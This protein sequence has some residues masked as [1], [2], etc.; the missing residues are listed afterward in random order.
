MVF[1]SG[2]L[3][4]L[5]A[6]LEDLV[7]HSPHD[8]SGNTSVTPCRNRTGVPSDMSDLPLT[9]FLTRAPTRQSQ[10]ASFLGFPEMHQ[11][12]FSDGMTHRQATKT[13]F[14]VCWFK[15]PFKC[16]WN[17]ECGVTKDCSTCGN[18]CDSD[19]C[20]MWEG[21]CRS[22]DVGEGFKMGRWYYYSGPSRPFRDTGDQ[23]RFGAQ[24]QVIGPGKPKDPATQTEAEKSQD[25][26][27]NKKAWKLVYF[28][29]NM[30]YVKVKS[31]SVDPPPLPEPPSKEARIARAD[32]LYNMKA[33]GIAMGMQTPCDPKGRILSAS[34]GT[35][36][37]D[38]QVCVTALPRDFGKYTGKFCWHWF[39]P[40]NQQVKCPDKPYCP[41]PPKCAYGEGKCPPHTCPEAK[42]CPKEAQCKRGFWKDMCRKNAGQPWCVKPEVLKQYRRPIEIKC[43][44]SGKDVRNKPGSPDGCWW[45]SKVSRMDFQRLPGK[46]KD[47][48]RTKPSG[49]FVT[50]LN[51][52]DNDAITEK[53]AEK[54]ITTGEFSGMQVE[55]SEFLKKKPPP[56]SEAQTA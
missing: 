8:D 56:P 47:P 51:K 10:A 38:D 15:P 13:S 37:E 42:P 41:P 9:S 2:A 11:D 35:F 1:H 30:R 52:E 5:K 6:L 26:E 46:I 18:N 31:L 43:S 20:A 16:Y 14:A 53:Q 4:H 34:D 22:R 48:N 17:D 21:K 7:H 45:L 55:N 3:P 36:C 12:N 23:T 33:A 32:A 25:I 39:Q 27:Q 49:W 24:V 19:D 44:A 40:E 50:G 29:G 28:P 54:W